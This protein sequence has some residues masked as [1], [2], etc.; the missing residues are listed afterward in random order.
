MKRIYYKADEVS[1]LSKRK[2]YSLRDKDVH[3]KAI[4]RAANLV[5]SYDGLIPDEFERK[6]IVDAILKLKR[7]VPYKS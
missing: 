2:T 6:V 5:K 1:V 3:N 7:K 4:T